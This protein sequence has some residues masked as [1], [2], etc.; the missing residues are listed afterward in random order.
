MANTLKETGCDTICL[1][2]PA[3]K[4]KHDIC[5]ELAQAA[6]KVGIQ[7]VLLINCTGTDYAD[8]KRQPPPSSS[9]LRVWTCFLRGTRRLRLDIYPAAGFYAEIILLYAPQA[10]SEGSL[11]LPIGKNI[12]LSW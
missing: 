11:T 1:V 4:D 5:V 8:P 9:S 3:H 7:N 12:S 2:P 10:Q 6:K